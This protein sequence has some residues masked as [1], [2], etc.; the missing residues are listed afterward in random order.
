MNL[1]VCDFQVCALLFSALFP[2]WIP[3]IGEDSKTSPK[4]WKSFFLTAP[5]LELEQI[6]ADA[7]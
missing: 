2:Q 7:L 3:G 6:S 1:N 4:E 5:F